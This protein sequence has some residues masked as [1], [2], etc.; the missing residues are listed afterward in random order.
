MRRTL[1]TVLSAV[2]LAT[3]A[4]V[5]I[6]ATPAG[7]VAKDPVVIVA[8]TFSPQ[9]YNEVLAGRLRADGYQVDIFVLPT[10]GTQDANKTSEALA[11]FVADVRARTGAA[12]VDLIGHS[13]GGV[14]AR[15]YVKAYGGAPYVDS[16]ITAGAPN[17]GTAPA[18]L[19]AALGFDDI[20]PVFEQLAI[21]SD[22]MNALN[23][24][25]DTIG[26]LRYT[27]FRTVYDVAAVPLSTQTLHDGATNVLI[28]SQC[29]FR[30]VG[31]IGL[32]LDGTV[33][34]GFKQ[35]LEGKTSIRLRCWAW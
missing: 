22:W 28:Q 25:D 24:G 8:G 27:T 14:I 33:Y 20:V 13:Q 32:F 30:V 16:L 29:P 3:L 21:G 17:R 26:D 7:A 9:F 2:L 5:G 19:A 4:V 31:H 6:P 35:A 15:Q 34:S 23:E 18:N 12:K 1:A 10:L 11:D